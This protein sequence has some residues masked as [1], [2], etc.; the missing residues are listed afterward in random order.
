M[1]RYW[2]CFSPFLTGR[3]CAFFLLILTP[4]LSHAKPNCDELAR[5]PE[6][7]TPSDVYNLLGRETPSQ[8]Q[9][10]RLFEEARTNPT[11]REELNEG[12]ESTPKLTSMAD[13]GLEFKKELRTFLDR[14]MNPGYS[15]LSAILHPTSELQRDFESF[16]RELLS[17]RDVPLTDLEADRLATNDTVNRFGGN[18]NSPELSAHYEVRHYFNRQKQRYLQTDT[19]RPAWSPKE[20]RDRFLHWMKKTIENYEEQRVQN[21]RLALLSLLR[22]EQKSLE[23]Q[24]LKAE[25]AKEGTFLR[26]NGIGSSLALESNQ[27]Q[28]LEMSVVQGNSDSLPLLRILNQPGV[29]IHRWEHAKLQLL[30]YRTIRG[31]ELFGEASGFLE[32][33]VLLLTPTE[34]E[35]LKNTKAIL[36][37]RKLPSS[38]AGI[39]G[40][41][42][43]ELLALFDRYIQRL[44]K[45]SLQDSS[46]LASE[47]L[48]RVYRDED[49]ARIIEGLK[50]HRSHPDWIA[51][52]KAI[53]SFIPEE[54]NFL[55]KARDLEK[56]AP[57]DPV[58]G[59]EWYGNKI[60]S[61]HWKNRDASLPKKST[62]PKPSYKTTES[63]PSRIW[64][65]VADR[66][67][68]LREI[69]R[70]TIVVG[71]VVGAAYVAVIKGEK[72]VEPVREK[73]QNVLGIER[74]V[75]NSETSGVL[76]TPSRPKPVIQL[77]GDFKPAQPEAGSDHSRPE[78]NET[79]VELFTVDAKQDTFYTLNSDYSNFPKSLDSIQ[80]S[81]NYVFKK[82]GKPKKLPVFFDQASNLELSEISKMK[83]ITRTV[84]HYEDQY[85]MKRDHG[86]A[87][88]ISFATR[89]EVRPTQGQL[90]LPRPEDGYELTYFNIYTFDPKLKSPI[91][92]IR[93]HPQTGQYLVEIKPEFRGLGFQYEAQFARVTR[94]KKDANRKIE[95]HPIDDVRLKSLDLNRL[96]K[97]T[98]DLRAAGLTHL[99]REMDRILS[100]SPSISADDLA[101][102]ISK[103]Q[104][105]SLSPGVAPLDSSAAGNPYFEFSQYLRQGQLFMKCDV[106]NHLLQTLLKDVL[107][108]SKDIHID[109]FYSFIYSPEHHG[110][111]SIGHART[112][113]RIDGLDTRKIIDATPSRSLDGTVADS[114]WEHYTP[115]AG[116]H[117][118]TLLRLHP[119][120]PPSAPGHG[121]P[122]GKGKKPPDDREP[123]FPPGTEPPEQ[124]KIETRPL[125]SDEIERLRKY[126]EEWLRNLEGRAEALLYDPIFVPIV[127]DRDVLPP[128]RIY[129]LTRGALRLVQKEI[130]LQAF[131]EQARILYPGEI[132]A[133]V[134]SPEEL[135]LL[136][137]RLLESEN[138]LWEK[139]NRHFELNR[140]SPFW[141]AAN[142]RFKNQALD[143]LDQ[144]QSYTWENLPEN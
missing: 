20:K 28:N 9:A 144:L 114:P 86:F 89:V 133:T 49:L 64:N 84:T 103:T 10:A 44:G 39:Y 143:L 51:F 46:K 136:F 124:V 69:T 22:H 109:H 27:I 73:V 35:F 45:T 72:Y 42:I 24:L 119:A 21:L 110:I 99:A 94:S 18:P 8:N 50:M 85:R 60:H 38:P 25:Y 107:Q 30:F 59:V 6:V 16:K 91:S 128:V 98:R 131:L 118:E 26:E 116:K 17:H 127:K 88:I 140:N 52:E 106:A 134:S 77:S 14:E 33:S 41:R 29:G 63:L 111:G 37:K 57:E 92:A 43:T 139:L 1:G 97:A 12:I 47:L 53:P 19:R 23:V 80:F 61:N 83:D 5:V 68:K 112:L 125:R 126:H 123:E 65:G 90:V 101:D 58:S 13:E 108:E 105:Y 132:P 82:A 122:E 75:S 120:P 95:P 135:K 4:G 141:F 2:D 79:Q 70:Q 66:F 11:L 117:E 113:I 104:I 87:Q 76:S 36:D 100:T 34:P 129:R 48:L 31:K 96:R 32:N 115:E 56:I 78:K 7:I 71:A 102:V 142:T 121:T 130:T 81:D 138:T 67:L 15:G 3:G 54:N 40:I 93:V 55:R 74:P 137:N 62:S